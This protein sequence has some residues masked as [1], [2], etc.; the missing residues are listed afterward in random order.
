MKVL[1]EQCNF[2]FFPDSENN[3]YSLVFNVFVLFCF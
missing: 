1:N 3:Q 2:F